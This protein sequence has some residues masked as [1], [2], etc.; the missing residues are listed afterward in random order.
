M[1][2][3]VYIYTDPYYINTNFVL[4]INITFLALYV[5][6]GGTT[7]THFILCVLFT[8]NGMYMCVYRP[9]HMPMQHVLKF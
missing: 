1:H 5:N 6:V 2:L 9:I 8:H 3:N 7:A 4:D